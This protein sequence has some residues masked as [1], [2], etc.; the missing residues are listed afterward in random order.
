[1][2]IYPEPNTLRRTRLTRHRN[3][4]DPQH[5]VMSPQCAVELGTKDGSFVR[6]YVQLPY[7]YCTNIRDVLF[8]VH[9]V[10]MQHVQ[11]QILGVVNFYL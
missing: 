2:K 11:L 9:L 6:R 1:M 5:A 7:E 8:D 3:K 10:A 4:G